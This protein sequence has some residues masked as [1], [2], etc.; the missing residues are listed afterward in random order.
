MKRNSFGMW[1]LFFGFFYLFF[2]F[3]LVGNLD[4]NNG[5]L[6]SRNTSSISAKVVNVI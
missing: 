6:V 1:S 4:M 5:D 3:L 2:L